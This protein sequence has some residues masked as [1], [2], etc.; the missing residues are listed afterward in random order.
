[1]VVSQRVIDL[2]GEV[3]RRRGGGGAVLL[4]PGDQLWVDAWIPREDP[5]WVADV[6]AAAAWVGAWWSTALGSLGVG[7]CEVHEGR[8]VPGT[9][10]GLVCF[11][12][13]GP[14]E[15]FQ[16]GRKLV[17]LSQWRSR[18]GALFYS[19]AYRYWAPGPLVDLLDLVPAARRALA[20]D[21]VDAAV[22]LEDLDPAVPDLATLRDALLTSFPTWGRGGPDPF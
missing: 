20:R 21:L 2:G 19:C 12:G 10:G 4:Q 11:S 6:S 16:R 3:M 5:L 15:V 17:G 7:G 1:V 14:G 18:E 13:R 8:A 22:G 9:H